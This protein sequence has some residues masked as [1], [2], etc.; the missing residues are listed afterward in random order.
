[1]AEEYSSKLL[2]IPVCSKNTIDKIKNKIL[3]PNPINGEIFIVTT[4]INIIN[5]LESIKTFP[6][7]S[8]LVLPG[9]YNL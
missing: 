6:I 3:T 8:I 4:F 1:M 2:L 5:K 7:T 9:A